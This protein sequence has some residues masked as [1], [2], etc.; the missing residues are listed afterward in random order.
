MVLELKYLNRKNKG[1]YILH[2][3]NTIEKRHITDVCYNKERYFENHIYIKG[4]IRR[5]YYFDSLNIVLFLP[6]TNCYCS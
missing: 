5:R 3:F 4:C 1:V 2:V 6:Q